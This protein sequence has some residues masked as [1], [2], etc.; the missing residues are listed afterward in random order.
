L[1]FLVHIGN[2]L[3]SAVEMIGVGE[4]LMRKEVALHRAVTRPFLAY[5]K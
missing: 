1:A 5:S 3:D 4:G 2:T